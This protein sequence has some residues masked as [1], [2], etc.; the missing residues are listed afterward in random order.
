MRKRL[1]LELKQKPSEPMNRRKKQGVNQLSLNKRI[2]D[3]SRHSNS[4]LVLVVGI[5]HL[6]L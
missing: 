3:L 6:G 2:T 5:V 4:D 1:A